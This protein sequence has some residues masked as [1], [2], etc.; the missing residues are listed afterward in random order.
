MFLF[1]IA[2]AA[3][4]RRDWNACV[5]VGALLNWFI[6]GLIINSNTG[7]AFVSV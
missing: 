1:H 6:I 3:C 4:G 7:A 5:L 2:V